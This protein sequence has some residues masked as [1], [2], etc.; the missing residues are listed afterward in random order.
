M[1]GCGL[2]VGLWGAF[3]FP[4]RTCEAP[5]LHLQSAV[6]GSAAAPCRDQDYLSQHHFPS[7]RFP[8]LRNHLR[9]DV[10]ECARH[11]GKASRSTR[12]LGRHWRA[13]SHGRHPDSVQSW[14][15]SANSDRLSFLPIF[16]K[17]LNRPDSSLVEPTQRTFFDFACSLFGNCWSRRSSYLARSYIGG[18]LLVGLRRTPSSRSRAASGPT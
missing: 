10:V 11:V 4:M 6:R 17:L 18:D 16:A 1:A 2:V 15:P 14:R 8:I 12:D 3:E 7:R 5:P 13:E 9:H